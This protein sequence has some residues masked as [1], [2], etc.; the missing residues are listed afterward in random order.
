M[1]GRNKPK[2]PRPHSVNK[3]QKPSSFKVMQ[4]NCNLF[5]DLSNKLHV[6]IILQN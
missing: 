4:F 6:R 1:E 2:F 5:L 3:F